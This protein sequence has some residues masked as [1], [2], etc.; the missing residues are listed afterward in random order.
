M[1]ATR[2]RRIDTT[3][4]AMEKRRRAF[5]NWLKNV[6]KREQKRKQLQQERIEA[7]RLRQLELEEERRMENDKKVREW[8]E[9]K[10]REAQKKMSRIHELKQATIDR[11]KAPKEFKKALR[12][13]EWVA[14]KNKDLKNTKEQQ[15]KEREM[16][17]LY[18]KTREVLSATSYK[19]WM[20]NSKNTAK[21]VPFN[22]GLDSLRGSTTSLFVNP[23]QWITD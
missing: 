16:E 8:N 20:H 23:N 2:L 4:E 6:T 14:K 3:P 21:P 10:R 7:E 17:N 1:S 12:F 19:K 11:V 15:A 5:E 9:K 13:D 22:R 18:S